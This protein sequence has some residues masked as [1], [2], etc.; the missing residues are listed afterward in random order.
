LGEL[1]IIGPGAGKYETAQAVLTDLVDVV[2][3]INKSSK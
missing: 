1:T 2:N 3:H